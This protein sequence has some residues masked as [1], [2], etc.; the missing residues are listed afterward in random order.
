MKR[1]FEVHVAGVSLY[2]LD[3]DIDKVKNITKN[4]P[5]FARMEVGEMTAFDLKTIQSFKGVK[6]GN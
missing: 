3:M 2:S 4:A 6:S 5:A 1:G